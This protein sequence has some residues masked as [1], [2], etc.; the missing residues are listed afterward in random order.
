M[1]PSSKYI[2]LPVRDELIFF[3]YYEKVGLIVFMAHIGSYVPAQSAS[4]GLVDAIYSRI[5]TLESISIGLSTF[6]VDLN[7]VSDI[8]L[9]FPL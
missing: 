9:S 7:Q 6:M 4:V 3:S 8:H 1:V 2:L 5:H